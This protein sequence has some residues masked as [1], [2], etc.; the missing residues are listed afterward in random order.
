MIVQFKFDL[1]LGQNNELETQLATIAAVFES[2]L[3][4]PSCLLLLFSTY[5]LMRRKGHSDKVNYLVRAANS[6]E[7][8][9]P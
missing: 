6:Y 9:R 1:L 2:K 5:E 3:Q 4:H 8:K 7:S